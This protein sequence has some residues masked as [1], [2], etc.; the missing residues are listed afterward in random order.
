MKTMLRTD[1][2]AD[3]PTHLAA[4]YV[5]SMVFKNCRS[6]PPRTGIPT[7]ERPCLEHIQQDTGNF[8]A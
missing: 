3:P 8:W 7:R 1:D 5:L 6:K 2:R 4:V